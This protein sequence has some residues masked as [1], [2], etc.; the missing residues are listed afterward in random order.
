MVGLSDAT[1]HASFKSITCFLSVSELKNT[2]LEMNVSLRYFKFQYINRFNKCSG[3]CGRCALS[4]QN[5]N[6]L[7]R[8]RH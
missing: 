7:E 4:M 5:L 3:L 2:F 8:A 1:L 6:Y